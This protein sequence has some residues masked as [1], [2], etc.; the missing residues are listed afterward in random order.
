METDDGKQGDSPKP[1]GD[2][3]SLQ[4]KVSLLHTTSVSSPSLSISAPPAEE[5]VDMPAVTS[6]EVDHIS[7][8][9]DLSDISEMKD[10][11]DKDGKEKYSQTEQDT[12]NE[13][14]A[15]AS[16]P[17]SSS[18]S[19]N[20]VLVEAVSLTNESEEP[21]CNINPS[22]SFVSSVSETETVNVLEK[23]KE[24]ESQTVTKMDI[25]TD[26][27][28]DTHAARVLSDGGESPRGSDNTIINGN[29]E[30]LS[31]TNTDS[32]K[33]TEVSNTEKSPEDPCSLRQGGED[34]PVIKLQGIK[35]S[36]GKDTDVSE[37]N[38]CSSSNTND[39][40]SV[41]NKNV[42]ER[43]E[44]DA[45]I[46]VPEVEHSDEEGRSAKV[47]KTHSSQ[48]LHSST[49]P[50]STQT[51]P[52]SN[53]GDAEKGHL[54]QE[55]AHVDVEET[56]KDKVDAETL[57]HEAVADGEPGLS[58]LQETMNCESLK[59]NT[60]LCLLPAVKPQTLE[61]HSS[62][63]K[64]SVGDEHISTNAKPLQ[65]APNVEGDGVIEKP[66]VKDCPQ[67]TSCTTSLI[68]SAAVKD[69]QNKCLEAFARLP[70]KQSSHLAGHDEASP[71][72]ASDKPP[73]YI[74]QVRSE[75]GPPLPPVI[76]PLSTPP[77]ASRSINPRQAI[78][79][80]SFPSPMDRLASPT[81]P[82][83]THTT[84]TRQHTNPS[85]LNS[86]LPPNGVPSSP[87]QFGS[88]TPKHAVP[89]PGRLP[90]TAMNSSPS[91][92][93][94]PSQENS[95]RM[96]DT[97]YPELSARARTLSILRGNVSLS[98]CPSDSGALPATD[99]Q[100]SGFKTINSI[101]T[102]FTKAE[103]RGAKRQASGSAQVKNNKC[104]RIDSC[105]PADSPVTPSSSNSGDE[106]VS[107][108]TLGPG[109]LKSASQLMTCG[110]SEKQD[111]VVNALNKVENQCFDLLPVIRSHL[112]VGT[113]PKKP[114]LRDEE[115]EVIAEICQSTLVSVLYTL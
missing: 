31:S 66:V 40:S 100:M 77:K 75:M 11:S 22:S 71:A 1:T 72:A 82:V 103:T 55:S 85:S 38:L 3:V 86:P 89:V 73:E 65:P 43:L 18:R 94:S 17:S 8:E 47:D 87:L 25:D 50:P 33:G 49:R 68:Q 32:V 60:P 9:N 83:T 56:A 26:P 80:L 64:L 59:E 2:S 14:V 34:V 84:P 90:P 101:S 4:E 30:D 44:E 61:T 20:T 36:L 81:T 108:Q 19:D 113:L 15:P 41:S 95:M 107:L 7:D 106:V 24:D 13:H 109:Q 52:L 58:D 91:S 10:K 53:T 74:G 88:A 76:T 78:G 5:N 96:L 79:K 111:L 16:S 67:D 12:G 112:F 37:D 29:T 35:C 6:H 57:N 27:S 62:P 51:L 102:A 99:S 21:S 23:A 70:E 92:A 98:I 105:S 69:G 46:N 115:K 54:A 97:M 42:G 39:F 110:E 114:V 63:G 93:S 48:Q 28:D 104:P 45:S